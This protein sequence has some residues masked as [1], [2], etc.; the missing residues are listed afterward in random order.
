MGSFDVPTTVAVTYC[1][2]GRLRKHLVEVLEG[3]RYDH[4]ARCVGVAAGQRQP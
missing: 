4:A 3:S 2:P 1:E